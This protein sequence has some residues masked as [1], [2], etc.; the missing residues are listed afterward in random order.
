MKKCTCGQM[1][2]L[3]LRTLFFSKKESITHVPVNV[4]E[5]CGV[6]ELLPCIKQEVVNYVTSVK[7]GQSGGEISLTD[8]YEPAALLKEILSGPL[9]D[10]FQLPEK[11]KDLIGEH[12]NMLLDLYRF[13]KSEGDGDWMADI[14]ERLEAMTV[15]LKSIQ[16]SSD[17]YAS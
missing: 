3:N 2:E 1:M 9:E 14:N 12:I 6:Y 11:C 17:I 10:S 5:D 15:F 4:C 16:P 13:A 8:L 7:A